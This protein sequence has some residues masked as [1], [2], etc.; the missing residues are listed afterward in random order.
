MFI[1]EL[2]VDELGIILTSTSS[3]KASSIPASHAQVMLDVYREL[4][5]RRA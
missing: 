3:R 2:S 4:T 5:K 1:D